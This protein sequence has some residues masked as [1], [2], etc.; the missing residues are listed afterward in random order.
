MG[1]LNG[2]VGVAP[3]LL[4]DPEGTRI[5]RLI[6]LE[7]THCSLH[8]IIRAIRLCRHFARSPHSRVSGPAQRL[9]LVPLEDPCFR[10][11]HSTGYTDS[12]IVLLE[13]CAVVVNECLCD[14]RALL[15]AQ[16]T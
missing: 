7:L 11:D 8:G 12:K 16:Y 10:P 4:A 13:L 15:S 9:P 2:S 14:Q 1:T 5:T 6:T 3:I